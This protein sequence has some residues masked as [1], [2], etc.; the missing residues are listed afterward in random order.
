MRSCKMNIQERLKLVARRR[1]QMT[2]IAKQWGQDLLNEAEGGDEDEPMEYQ[3]W[4]EDQGVT[5]G[6]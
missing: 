2:P 4:M 5:D 1:E 3:A 6:N